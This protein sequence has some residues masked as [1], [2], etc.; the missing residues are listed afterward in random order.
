MVVDKGSELK[1]VVTIDCYN[2]M[3]R[4]LKKLLRQK[5][6]PQTNYRG[7]DPQ[8]VKPWRRNAFAAL[9]GTIGGLYV[10]QYFPDLYYEKVY[11]YLPTFKEL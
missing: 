10:G 7:T 2:S 3:Q 6:D 8:P 5:V 9:I 4:I 11:E 1:L